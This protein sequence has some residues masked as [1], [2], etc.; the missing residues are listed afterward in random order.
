GGSMTGR[1][2]VLPQ[3]GYTQPQRLFVSA[4]ECRVR[5][6]P[7][8]GGAPHEIDLTKLPVS[9]ELR[10]WFAVAVAEATGP[11][12][13]LRRAASQRNALRILKRFTRYLSTLQRPP[14][15]PEQLRRAHIDGFV[16]AGGRSL[17]RDLGSLR[18]LLRHADPPA[19][20][21]FSARLTTA[22]S[23]KIDNPVSSYSETEFRRIIARCKG[24]LR[25]A[26][27]RIRQGR[28]DLAAW[29]SGEVDP[30]DRRAWERGRLLDHVDRHGDVPRTDRPDASVRDHGGPADLMAGLHLTYDEVTAAAVLLICLTG[31]NASTIDSATVA[32]LRPDGNTGTLASAVVDLVKPRRGSRSAHMSVALLDASPEGRRG[33]D[34]LDTPFGVYTLLVDLGQASRARLGTDRLL[35]FYANSGGPH[36]RGF[37][38][39]LPSQAIYMW[40]RSGATLRCDPPAGNEDEQD[41]LLHLDARRLRLTFLELHQRPVAQTERTLVNEYL[42]R[43]RGNIAEYQRLVATVLAQ[44]VD[45]ARASRPL[46]VLSTS[47]VARAASDPATVAAAQDMPPDAVADLMSGRLDTVLA[48]CIDNLHSPHGEAGSPCTA[49][50]LLCL[51]CPC[52]RATP[53]HLPVQVLVHDELLARRGRMTPL[54]WAQRFATPATQLAD[55]LAQYGPGAVADA[56]ANATDAQRNLVDRFLSRELD[57]T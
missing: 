50:F 16:I 10:E 14:R 2:A 12:G 9:R 13:P 57:W 7:E 54:A 20:D 35:A 56:R 30:S 51:S 15:R 38:A 55:L 4:D 43:N 1:A 28:A 17:H 19:P 44:Q 26:E 25:R 45:L 8:D 22:S 11:S 24:E 29:R 36:G 34:K 18:S 31:Q 42:A 21:G 5:A 33:G 39:G 40:S 6:F 48:G 37:R 47:D 27:A 49:S 41:P 53:A 23:P 52:A 3:P 32:H 46:R